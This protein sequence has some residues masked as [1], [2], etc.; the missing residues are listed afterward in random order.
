MSIPLRGTPLGGGDGTPRADRSATV[1]ASHNAPSERAMSG[2]PSDH[3]ISV[4]LGRL[5]FPEP[6]PTRQF[7]GE[8]ADIEGYVVAP[9][10]NITFAATAGGP[11][12]IDMLDSIWAALRRKGIGVRHLTV[13]ND[14]GRIVSLMTLHVR[15][16]EDTI[17]FLQSLL[18]VPVHTRDGFAEVHCLATAE[19][20]AA[21]QERAVSSDP[22]AW[23]VPDAAYAHARESGPL[24]PGDWAFLG[25]LSAVGAL[26]GPD[27]PSP[28]LVADAL[29]LDPDAFAKQARAVERGLEG[30]VTGLFAPV[31]VGAT[32]E[33]VLSTR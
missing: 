8:S 23:G 7:P 27:G 15:A 20:V 19:E 12:G 14:S 26:D 30:V 5:F 28:T 18:M 31:E 29:G 6:D 2:G 32:P 21:L 22:A 4:P 24:Q 25:L 13:I 10:H 17:R 16:S 1:A 11:G 33:R 3:A 9:G